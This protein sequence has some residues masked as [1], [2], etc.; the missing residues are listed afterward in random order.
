MSGYFPTRNFTGWLLI[1]LVVFGNPAKTDALANWRTAR[2]TTATITSDD[3]QLH[4]PLYA[5]VGIIVPIKTSTLVSIASEPFNIDVV[6]VTSGDLAVTWSHLEKKIRTES[7]ILASCRTSPDLCSFAAQKFLAIV[8]EGRAHQG[9]AR[10]AVINRAINLAIQP[11]ASPLWS[12]PVDTLFTGR[13]DCKDY[14]VAKYVALLEIGIAEADVS[15]VILRDLTVGEN[16]AVVAVRFDG[17]WIV[18]DNRRFALVEDVEMRRVVP[19]FVLNHDGIKLY[20]LQRL[21]PQFAQL[22]PYTSPAAE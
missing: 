10:I 18:L 9:L 4:A 22:A 21:Q 1:L 3:G 13:G 11:Q 15:L 20:A 17:K 19:L 12:T 5:K 16:H 14:A 7:E 6:P 2:T 8:A